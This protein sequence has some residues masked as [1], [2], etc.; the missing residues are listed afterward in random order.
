MKSTQ[1]TISDPSLVAEFVGPEQFKAF[2]EKRL[3]VPPDY[4]GLLMRDGKFV[5]AYKGAHFSVGGVMNQ[6]AGIIGGS[7]SVSVL[8]A[9]LKTFQN[10]YGFK[11]ITKDKV[12]VAG[13]VVMEMQINPEKPQNII[14]LM[15][16]RKALSKADVATRLK[17]LLTDRVFEASVSRMNASEVRGNRG[18]QDLIQADV[19]KEVER[20]AGDLGL[21]IRSTAVEWAI[22][23]VEKAEMARA[24]AEREA[25]VAEYQFNKLKRQMERDN[26]TTTFQITS[27]RDI[28]KLKLQTDADLQRLVMD[29]EIGFVDARETGKRVQEM[30]VLQHEIDLLKNERLAKFDAEIATATHQGVDMK[31][32]EE[33]KR[34]IERETSMLDKQHDLS[35]KRLEDQYGREKAEEDAVSGAKVFHTQ[36]EVRKTDAELKALEAA[37]ALQTQIA[38]DRAALDKLEGLSGL[39]AKQDRDRLE[40]RLKE[41]EAKHKQEMDKARLEAEKEATRM[42]KGAKMTPEQLLALNAGLSPAVAKVL[43]EQAKAGAGGNQQAMDLMKQM[44]AMADKNTVQSAEQAKALA[45]MIVQSSVG[46]AQGA[47]GKP[48]TG[49][50][51]AMGAGS[52]V[53]C[54]KCGRTNDAKDRYCVGCGEQLRK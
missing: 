15:D 37:K 10:Q 43:E 51:G 36:A 14:G 24:T 7:H 35:L 50:G 19:M 2:F 45:Q 32:V 47:A 16:G 21:L 3:E 39:Q 48:V 13:T 11:A 54:P 8:L 5:Q 18:L 1:L 20:V 29:Q 49:G 44:V 52:T 17:N 4:M 26:E 12:E 38:A 23:E 6:L 33:R 30:K 40:E 53:D 27:K 9:D 28:D 25:E 31:V 42:E 34:K 46:V 22:N 41:G